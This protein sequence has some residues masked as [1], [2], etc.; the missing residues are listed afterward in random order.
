MP[1]S[2]KKEKMDMKPESKIWLLS[3]K[4]AL[5]YSIYECNMEREIVFLKRVLS[6]M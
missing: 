6:A 2:R 5:Q 1:K 4:K 3:L